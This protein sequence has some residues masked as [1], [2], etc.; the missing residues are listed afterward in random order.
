[1]L[2]DIFQSI[3]YHV[4]ISA[5]WVFIAWNIDYYEVY[6]Y[7]KV[8]KIIALVFKQYVA[9]MILNYAYVGILMDFSRPSEIFWYATISLGIIT[10][11]KFSK[12]GRASCRE[13]V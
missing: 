1:M 7:T 9:F 4:F 12:I 8:I 5:A 10:F 2:P 6:R 3:G 11:F 13:R